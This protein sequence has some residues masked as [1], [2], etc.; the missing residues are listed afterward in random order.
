M[1]TVT[2]EPGVRIQ[3]HAP[4]ANWHAVN[5]EHLLRAD[6][7]RLIT[8][9]ELRDH[10]FNKQVMDD[11]AMAESFEL[12]Q[13]LSQEKTVVVE[14]PTWEGVPVHCMAVYSDGT[15]AVVPVERVTFKATV[16]LLSDRIDFTQ[17]E[18]GEFGGFAFG[19]GTTSFE[20]K[21]ARMV[22]AGDAE[23]NWKAKAVW[24]FVVR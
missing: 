9:T 14:S 21:P 8:I 20:G 24:Q 5:D 17:T 18:H 19:T 4:G 23:G 15:Q 11:P 16:E 13:S 6:G 10:C 12:Q 7:S 2:F 22:I 3:A 1:A